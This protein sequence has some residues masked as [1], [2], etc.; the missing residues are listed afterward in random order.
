MYKICTGER[1]ANR[2]RDFQNCLLD[3]MKSESYSKASVALLCSKIGVS[4]NTFYKYFDSLNDVLDAI[5][6]EELNLSWLLMEGNPQIEAYFDY[7]RGQKAFL[8][9]LVEN[10]M[11]FKLVERSYTIGFVNYEPEDYAKSHG[12]MIT[13]LGGTICSVCLWYMDG[14]KQSSKEMAQS[15]NRAF[16][17]QLLTMYKN[18]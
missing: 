14:M 10:G 4:R 3:I 8:D 15:V 12:E 16:R 17:S 1:S 2:Q 7:W 11:L 9:L 6:D 18:D 13:L 5:I